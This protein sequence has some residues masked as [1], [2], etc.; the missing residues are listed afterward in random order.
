MGSPGRFGWILGC[1]ALA[2]SLLPAAVAAAATKPSTASIQQLE[3]RIDLPQRTN[4]TTFWG[5]PQTLTIPGKPRLTVLPVSLPLPRD[6]VQLRQLQVEPLECS[7]TPTSAQVEQRQ[8]VRMSDG[9]VMPLLLSPALQ[10]STGLWPG[11]AFEAQP[12]QKEGR[13]AALPLALFAE[14]IESR[15]GLMLRCTSFRVFVEVETQLPQSSAA[16]AQTTH[17]LLIL[18]RAEFAQNSTVLAD[19]LAAKTAEGLNPLVVTEEEIQEALPDPELTRPER[20]RKWLQQNYQEMGFKYLLI[21]GDPRADV[22]NSIP[23]QT[24]FPAKGYDDTQDDVP[25]DMYYSDLT[26]EWDW[27]QNGL[28]CEL[29]D[30]MDPMTGKK[31]GGVDLTPELLV[32]RIPHQGTSPNYGDEVLKRTL[33]YQSWIGMAWTNRVLLPSPLVTFPDGNY[34]DITQVA[35]YLIN[36]VL[37]PNGVPFW[38]LGEADGNL[39]GSAPY[40]QPLTPDT[41]ANSWEEGYGVVFWCAHGN[42]TAAYR[43]IWWK[44]D[45]DDGLPQQRE[46]EEPAFIIASDFFQMVSEE[47][48]PIVFQAS[49]LNASPEEPGNLAHALLR[50]CSIANIASSRITMGLA[51]GGEW[52]PSPFSPGAFTMGVYFVHMMMTGDRTIAEAFVSAKQAVSLGVEPWTYKMRLEF[53]LYGDPTTRRPK[54]AAD[55]ECDDGSVCTGLEKCISGR[56]QPGAKLSC[57][58]PDSPCRASTCDAQSGCQMTDLPDGASCN[59][60]LLCTVSDS[61]KEG[62]CS[63]LSRICTS[64]NP[65]VLPHC[66]PE[67]GD[68]VVKVLD[69]GTDCETE[70]GAGKCSAGM[71]F[72]EPVTQVEPDADARPESTSDQ[73]STADDVGSTPSSGG[74]QTAQQAALTAP[75]IAVLFGMLAALWLVSA[76]LRKRQRSRS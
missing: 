40:D 6:S 10:D 9:K 30:Y 13:A 12:I 23:M 11:A 21:I 53:N 16:P 59:D 32:G 70:Q 75:S 20:I 18:T 46:V 58:L 50:R 62:V 5:A 31:V 54:C 1:G 64:T 24:C 29:E 7:I 76:A 51:P 15:S 47:H 71:C 74:C 48:P 38:V 27:N 66:D 43:D 34:V 72:V 56:C 52:E 37:V 73:V 28:P 57:P 65:C 8:M 14:R 3:W 61:C 69:E 19:Y 33:A 44:D 60:G 45:N 42:E 63:G 25:T 67:S 68:C 26:G 41:I 39:P 17:P 2:L 49:C 36:K 55:S 35:R 4:D 22:P